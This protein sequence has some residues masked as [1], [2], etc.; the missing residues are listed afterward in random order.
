[1][2]RE[3]FLKGLKQVLEEKTPNNQHLEQLY[4]K[5]DI[6]LLISSK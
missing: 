2:G 3:R 4:N 5:Y 1:M 6:V